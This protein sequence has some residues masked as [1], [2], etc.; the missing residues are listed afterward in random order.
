M[1]IP[2]FSFFRR[3]SSAPPKSGLSV[4]GKR[5]QRKRGVAIITV[6]SIISLMT[7]LVISFFNMAQN[8][9]ATS[10]GTVD[11][12]RVQSIKD[13]AINLVVAQIREATTLQQGSESTIWSSQPGAI[14]TYGN[15]NAL[16][17]IYKLYSAKELKIDN[18]PPFNGQ[19]VI[20]RIKSDIPTG[21]D[22]FP[23]RYVDLNKPTLPPS[24]RDNNTSGEIK[25]RLVYPIADPRRY[26]GKDTQKDLEDTEGFS[27]GKNTFF[28]RVNG[29]D[30]DRGQLAMPVQWIY[31]LEDGTLGYLDDTN[32]FRSFQSGQGSGGDKPSKTIPIIGR[33]AWWTDDESCK[34]N[35]N[36]A[37][38]PIMWDTPRLAS[39]EDTYY[40]QHQP[41]TG[42]VQH[43]P[44]HPAQVDL[45]AVFFPSQRYT[46]D[47][48]SLSPGSTFNWN[49]LSIKDA[50]LLW[51]IAPFVTERGGTNGGRDAV[52]AA[53]AIPVPLD[54]DDHL[55]ASIDEVYFKAT[56]A[57]KNLNQARQNIEEFDDAKKTML[58]RLAQSQ[59][60]LT[61]RSSS[62]ELT[63]FGTPRICMYPLNVKT[64]EELV[65]KTGSALSSDV[66]GIEVSMALNASIGGLPYFFQ[67]GK[68]SQG[69]R[70]NA[71]F[72]TGPP[73]YSRNAK[74]FE[75]L[76]NLT[77]GDASNPRAVPGYP[78]LPPD[79]ATFAQKYPRPRYNGTE[80]EDAS[81]RTIFDATD[82]TQIL[83][84]MVDFMRSC[85]TTP[86]YLAAGNSYSDGGLI[87]GICGC[88][89]RGSDNT[90]EFHLRA[91]NG[92]RRIAPKGV[93][94]NYGAAEIA[95]IAGVPLSKS[96]GVEVGE[97]PQLTRRRVPAI[98]LNQFDTLSEASLIELGVVVN[99]FTPKQG[100]APIFTDGGLRLSGGNAPT[101]G[102]SLLQ[103]VGTPTGVSAR[104]G[105]SE[106]AFYQPVE[107]L[108]EGLVGKSNQLP[109]NIAPWGGI[110]GPRII[111]SR[112]PTSDFRD[113]N[114]PNGKIAS[115]FALAVNSPNV[116]QFEIAFNG[117]PSLTAFGSLRVLMCDNR[118]SGDGNVVQAIDL[119]LSGKTITF[120]NIVRGRL[121]E[122]AL[123]PDSF[124]R[125]P[126]QFLRNQ[127]PVS[128]VV[129]HGDYR[130]V[131]IPSRVPSGLFVPIEQAGTHNMAEP[132]LDN[133][134]SFSG[135]AFLNGNPKEKNPENK[136]DPQQLLYDPGRSGRPLGGKIP[137]KFAPLLP[138]VSRGDLVNNAANTPPKNTITL[139]SASGSTD[140]LRRARFAH[141]RLD[142]D[143]TNVPH[144]GS[145]DPLET[146]D[147]DTGYS[148][149]PDGAY[150]NF[151]D[152]GDSR[153]RTYPYFRGLDKEA[154]DNGS[155]G[156]FSPNRLLRSAVDFGSIPSGVNAR[157]PW[158]TLRFRPDPKSFDAQNRIRKPNSDFKEPRGFAHH[159]PFSNYCGPRDHMLL[160]FFWVPVVEPW[161]ISEGFATKG[162]INLN[163]Q[164]FPFL[165]IDRLTALHAILRGT[166]MSAVANTFSEDYKDV[167]QVNDPRQYRF[168]INASQTLRQLT[169]FRFKGLD[170]YAGDTVPFNSFRS[171]SELCELWLV[172]E[173]N[174]I[175][176]LTLVGGTQYTLEYVAA[177]GGDNNSFWRDNALTGDNLR[178]RPYSE[179]YP[180]VTTRSNVYKIHIVAQTLKKADSSDP[181]NFSSTIDSVTAEWRGSAMIERTINPKD[182]RLA[183][184]DYLNF[185]IGATD[186]PKLDYFY[187]YRV[188]EVTQA[189]Q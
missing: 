100:W 117:S 120:S 77:G 116:S 30:A 2:R 56:R 112:G 24:S 111:S 67:R 58:K 147:F 54:N 102:T 14:R 15:Q 31:V 125:E 53:T 124:N 188:T 166:R 119:E 16:N 128:L 12:Q 105:G 106:F 189:N 151:P 62:P 38:C 164:I 73:D 17:T 182:P 27:Y 113:A 136:D 83:L 167:Q 134:G 153:D 132:A 75:Y 84:N 90:G 130:L 39:Q 59:F 163:Q 74:V 57:S 168:W 48:Q 142:G 165:Y 177:I 118:G 20:D 96:G 137:A 42:E 35:V 186:L 152:E 70:H 97:N 40:A 131:T 93:G 126:G 61:H 173:A 34:I 162:T 91:L 79:M 9:R 154:P 43:F 172:P 169:E 94:R 149:C 45:S 65:K 159:F 66:G 71:F 115:L 85:N 109:K 144:R 28:P 138:P 143:G 140:A 145:S 33:I 89:N 98:L 8:Q 51:N 18:I 1:K 46:P 122:N 81:P 103:P 123:G 178:E 175:S 23:E 174:Q 69:S 55:Y 86:G 148:L 139:E 107:G 76:W 49:P 22:A 32:A 80:V 78:E 36:T 50:Q 92:L 170:V 7:I 114:H 157:V 183:R 99:S 4:A 26:D 101:T 68:D 21:W 129:P 63:V 5:H 141:G 179:I 127:R 87:S 82:R 41:V 150:M 121:L 146:G 3:S 37:S 185:K 187:T 160:D 156:T 158:Q 25:D 108:A 52:D 110:L 60:F 181:K 19:F 64:K 88:K 72:D 176:D 171:A 180:R 29:V 135:W 47:P 11:I 10:A 95:F 155:P 161:A 6:L 184:Y 13:T 44:G 133:R 104:V